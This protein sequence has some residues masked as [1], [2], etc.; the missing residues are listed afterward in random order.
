MPRLGHNVPDCGR[1]PRGGARGG[2]RGGDGGGSGAPRPRG[3]RRSRRGGRPSRWECHGARLSA[4]AMAEP[5][6]ATI[7]RRFARRLGRWAVAGGADGPQQAAGVFGGHSGTHTKC[8]TPTHAAPSGRPRRCPPQDQVPPS[9]RALPLVRRPATATATATAASTATA[10]RVRGRRTRARAWAPSVG[11]HLHW[12]ATLF[13][14]SVSPAQA[15]PTRRTV[16]PSSPARI[17][18]GG[19]GARGGSKPVVTV[20][21][22]CCA[23]RSAAPS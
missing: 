19:Q 17:V 3:Q 9:R 1:R 2:S 4:N 14:F 20:R 6:S 11:D 10:R 7:W 21:S 23:T 12:R 13:L 5:P 15:A 8:K 16:P 22:L 18:V